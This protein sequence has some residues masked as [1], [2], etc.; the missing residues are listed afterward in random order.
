MSIFILLFV[1]SLV[2]MVWRLSSN[3]RNLPCPAW[4]SWMIALDNP[5]AKA[6]KAK[7][8]IKELPLKKGMKVL[9]VGCGPGR[10]LLPLAQKIKEIDG[11]V[12]GLD[13]Q[14]DMLKK[15]WEK[16]EKNNL[17]NIDF[18]EGNIG[19]TSL[20]QT[21][22][23]ILL[24]CV[25]GEIPKKDWELTIRQLENYLHQEGIISITETIFDPH[26][27][28]HQ[29]VTQIM[30]KMGLMEINF[31]GNRFAYTAHFKKI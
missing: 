29:T 22:D 5:F 11:Q 25:L 14:K 31:I 18:I 24:I 12:T 26:F 27:Q 3:Y 15:S 9:D 23:V 2:W 30:K 19:K 21:Y 4:L 13:L 20:G 1:L 16:A 10:V 7:E 8:I 6:H 17:E 28:K